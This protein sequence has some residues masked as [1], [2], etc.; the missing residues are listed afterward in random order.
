MFGG[1][2]QL[3]SNDGTA[4]RLSYDKKKISSFWDVLKEFEESEYF[5]EQLIPK[6]LFEKWIHEQI[7]IILLVRQIFKNIIGIPFKQLGYMVYSHLRKITPYLTE[8]PKL[9]EIYYPID[10]YY[11]DNKIK[12]LTLQLIDG[13]KNSKRD[14]ALKIKKRLLKQYYYILKKDNSFNSYLSCIELE[15]SPKLIKILLNDIIEYYKNRPES[16]GDVTRYNKNFKYNCSKIFKNHL[17]SK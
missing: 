12:K 16:N 1:L 4:D 10:D 13:M 6:I 8:P 7:T 9:L 11:S 5:N 3:I 17:K 15:C 2:F 14:T